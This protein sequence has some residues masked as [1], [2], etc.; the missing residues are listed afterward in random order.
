MNAMKKATIWA[1]LA[2]LCLV[3]MP[4]AAFAHAYIVNS[5]PAQNQELKKAPVQ[6]KIEFNEAIQEGFHSITVRNSSG[7]RVD[8]GE[9]QIDPKNAK[10]LTAKLDKKLK[11]DIY[12]AEW[13]V[14]SA[15]GHPVSGTIP[16]SVG[17][18]QGGLPKDQGSA[19]ADLPKADTVIERVLLYTGFS[20]FM[21]S[22]LFQLVWYRPKNSWAERMR[23][24]LQ[25]IIKLALVMIGAA[26]VIQLPLQTKAN[27][28]VSWAEAFQPALLKETLLRTTGGALWL[29]SIGLIVLLA[30]CSRK[31]GWTA[32]ILK[33]IFFAGLLLAKS[34][35]GH[36]ASTSY[37]YMTA[38]MDFIHL[39]AASVWTG[40]LAALVLFF[41]R[42]WLKP[43]KGH[44]WEAIR[45]FSPWALGSAGLLVFSG[46][47][48]SFFIVHTMDNL[49]QTNY[50]KALLIK[51]AL[52]LLMIGFGALHYFRFRKK[53]EHSRG[54]TIRAEWAIGLLI[55]VTTA[56]FTNI[57]S[58][59][60]PLPQPF[61]ETKQL[62][63]G[64]TLSLRISPNMPGSNTFEVVVRN[65]NGDVITDIQKIELTVSKTGIFGDNKES[66]FTLS[67][68]EKGVFQTKN[69]HLNEEGIWK[70]RVHGLTA[71]FD[72][73]R[74]VFNAKI[75]KKE[76]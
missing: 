1:V 12:T 44:I 58:P 2:V 65:R 67:K 14:V 55:L 29:A 68:K 57:P 7:E 48:N 35:S 61:N 4:K 50:G 66:T 28:G 62:A 36:A 23:S 6:I 56:V 52:V 46:L 32:N 15:D 24:R 33:I 60:A 30:V 69:L 3:L 59:P 19:S 64:E 49:F 11:N 8:S 39:A 71:S 27:A 73:I 13:R 76:S 22:I 63:D 5:T 74:T 41:G 31:T 54:N 9:A 72:E 37:S 47:L 38:A 43:D 75:N 53:P 40:G 34:L 21:G 42:D 18:I 45:R 25:R 20:L 16:F 51:S 26:I 10:I 70:I 17:N